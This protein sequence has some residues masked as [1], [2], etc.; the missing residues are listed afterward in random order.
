[1]SADFA[2]AEATEAL[3]LIKAFYKIKDLNTRRMIVSIVKA[4]AGSATVKIEEPAELSSPHAAWSIR[5]G[6]TSH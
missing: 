6:N 4:A 3:R 5:C 2:D 1:M